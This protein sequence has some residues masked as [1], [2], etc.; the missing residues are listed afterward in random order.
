VRVDVALSACADAVG[1]GR[2]PGNII[3]DGALTFGHGELIN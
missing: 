3:L 2:G 1:G